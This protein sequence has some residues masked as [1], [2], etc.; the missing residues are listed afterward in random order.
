MVNIKIDE[1]ARKLHL[2]VLVLMKLTPCL[3][4]MEDY[5]HLFDANHQMNGRA[6]AYS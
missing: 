3:S 4:P 5:R 2:K 1:S 6:I